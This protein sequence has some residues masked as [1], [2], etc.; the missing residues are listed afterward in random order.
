MTTATK[1]ETCECYKCGG[2]GDIPAFS[3]I[4]NGICFTCGGSGRVTVK[5]FKRTVKPL[6]EYQIKII[7]T[8][9]NADLS[10]MSFGQLNE[11][12]N[13]AHWKYPQ[14]PKLLAIWRERGDAYFFAAQEERLQAASY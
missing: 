1:I 3:G 10:G 14:E 13:A 12:R 6:T 2:S 4:A 9:K 7:D 8:I 11:L 5:A